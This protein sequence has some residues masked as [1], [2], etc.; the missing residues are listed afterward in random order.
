VSQ[1]DFA[2]PLWPEPEAPRERAPGRRGARATRGGGTSSQAA[3]ELR[4]RLGLGGAP[5]YPD[6]GPGLSDSTPRSRTAQ[7]RQAGGRGARAGGYGARNDAGDRRGNVGVRDPDRSA[8]DWDQYGRPARTGKRGGQGTGGPGRGSRGPGGGGPRP[9]RRGLLQRLW[10][11]SWWRRWTWRKALLVLT[12]G[13]LLFALA[14]LGLFA[15]AY[16]SV[17]IPTAELQSALQQSS[18]VYFAGG[19]VQVG[20]FGSVNRQIVQSRQI[21]ASMK[22]ATIAAEDRNFYSEGGISLTGTLRAVYAD[23][24]GGQFQGGSTITQEFVR[25]FYANIGTQQTV[26]RKLKE[27]IVAIKISHERSKDWILTEYLNTVYL[28]R[29][30]YG[31]QAAAG[32]YFG[33]PASKL[34][35]SQAAMLAAMIQAPSA[36]DPD[37]PHAVVSSLGES[38]AWRWRYVLTNMVRDGAISQQTAAAQKFPKVIDENS[39]NTWHGFRGYVMQAV[40]NELHHTYGLS[41]AQIDAGGYQ[42]VTTVS[43]RKMRALYTAVADVKGLMRQYGVPLPWYAHIGAVL[44]QPG[45]GAILAWYGGPNFQARHKYCQLISCQFDYSLQARQQ[46]GS[47][48]KPYVLATAVKQGMNVETSQL[49]ADSPACVPPDTQPLAPSIPGGDGKTCLPAHPLYAPVGYD[50]V[51]SGP[52]SVPKAAAVS[53]NPAFMDLTHRVGTK[54]VIDLATQFGVDTSHAYSEKK[55][56][57]GTGSGLDDDVGQ[58]GISLGIAPLTVEEQAS[59]FA[60]FANT[61]QPGWYV[62]PHVIASITQNGRSIPL[63]LAQR[64]VL[65]PQQVADVDWALSFDTQYGTAVPNA[66]LSPYRP[67]IAK[68]GT[69]D[70]SQSAFFIGALPGQYSFAVMMRTN[71]QNNQPGGQTLSVLPSVGGIAGGY[72]GAWPATLWRIYM[73]HLLASKPIAQLAP[74]DTTGMETWIQLQP[75]PAPQP[76]QCVPVPQGPPCP[77]P[78]PSGSPTPSGPPTPTPP[79]VPPTVTPTPSPPITPFARPR[80]HRAHHHR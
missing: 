29:G 25:N 13:F 8:R 15:M 39:V 32:T 54:N 12:G 76:G 3:D 23:V 60:T 49:F 20:S 78:S 65:T 6:G 38:L 74:P 1:P 50:P 21:S 19:K 41:Y 56:P 9:P 58:V 79:P 46:V 69:T 40:R 44:E 57:H 30:A 62:A 28:G 59:T 45:T 18:K 4:V 31:V 67:T 77:S 24:T 47:S 43:L 64:Q 36:F 70:V 7:A 35:V 17:Q 55:Y 51:A 42:V 63:K 53:S 75:A 66:V 26:S 5:G 68:T 72:G 10:Y 27:I 80:H 61:R 14:L 33:V 48:F 52:V 16:F 2:G 37:H 22:N 34:T 11:G 71:K 73:T